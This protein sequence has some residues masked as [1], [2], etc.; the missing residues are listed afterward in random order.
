MQPKHL[1]YIISIYCLFIMAGIAGVAD[2][3]C[4]FTTGSTGAIFF[5]NIDPST[6]PGPVV[7]SVT[8]QINFTCDK[9]KSFTVT[10]NPASGWTLSSG[11]NSMPYTLGF[12]ASGT[13][14]NASTPIALL[15]AT[16]TNI[17]KASYEN[18]PAGSY[19]NNQVT[20]TIN[21]PTCGNPKTITAT[22]PAGNVSGTVTNTCAVTQSAG[23]LTFNIDP[24]IAG[25]TTGTIAQ[26]LKIKCTKSASIAISTSSSCGGASPKLS[27]SYPAC[28]GYQI[29]YTF[30]R[31]SGVIGLG[32]GAGT[33]LAL[34][35]GGSVNSVDYADAPVGNYGD[36]ET[37]TITY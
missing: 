3:G 9:N 7:G 35:I 24:S 8:T 31:S 10:A 29:P 20:F 21:C 36:L 16:G 25:T 5:N 12:T 19:T 22:I 32:F 6:T 34:G 11:A 17:I 18:A 37:V 33:D 23:T 2:A 27:S 13:F 26:D 1:K 28:G 15:T 14:D 30:S 4:S